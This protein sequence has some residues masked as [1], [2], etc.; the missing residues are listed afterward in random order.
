M[1][2]GRVTSLCILFS[3]GCYWSPT[4]DER[5]QQ[6]VIVTARDKEQDFGAFGSFFVRPEIRL[7]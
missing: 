6:S 5:L 7:L 3:T 2:W 1:R 4:A